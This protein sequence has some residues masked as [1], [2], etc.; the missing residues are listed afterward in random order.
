MNPASASETATSTPTRLIACL[1][2][3]W[4]GTCRDYRPLF[5]EVMARHPQAR[6]AWVDIEDEAD[7]VGDIDVETFPTLLIVDGADRVRFFGPLL[8][9]AQTL[10]RLVDSLEA[11]G[12]VQA[13]D[14][15]VQALAQRL[16][17]RG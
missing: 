1:C 15:D 8:P 10:A 16:A 4:C 2:A 17:A 13:V 9:H 7:L 5:D 6:V 3:A 12:P 14:A 11:G